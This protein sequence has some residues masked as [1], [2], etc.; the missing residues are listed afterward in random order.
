[1]IKTILFDVDGVLLN[2]Q[3]F[4]IELEREYGISYDMT[5]PFF[6]GP[7]RDSTVGLRDMKEVLE[8]YLKEWKWPHGTDDF[9]EYWFTKE[10]SIDQSLINYIQRLRAAGTKCYLATN[11]ERYRTTY[12]MERMGFADMFDGIFV[13]NDL[14]VKKPDVAFFEKAHQ[15][16]PGVAKEEILFWDD[17]AEN[18]AAAEAYGIQAELYTNF[19]D[20]TKK[21]ELYV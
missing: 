12:I 18:V 15:Q 8:P 21:M 17:L 10:H 16:I 7:F 19:D 5:Q 4:T 3:S 13:S 6:K 1:M 20:F 11:Q 2:G 14:G 9:L